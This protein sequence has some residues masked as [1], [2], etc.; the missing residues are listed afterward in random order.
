MDPILGKKIILY[1]G[2]S[3]RYGYRYQIDF[4]RSMEVLLIPPISKFRA[5]QSSMTPKSNNTVK[6]DIYRSLWCVAKDGKRAK[7]KG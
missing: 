4:Q 7:L 2:V 1:V 3:H 5:I 6:G